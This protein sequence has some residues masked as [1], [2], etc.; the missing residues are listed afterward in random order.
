MLLEGKNVNLRIMEREDLATL[1]EW[2]NN[3]EFMGEYWELKQESKTELEKTYDNL[4]DEQWF[5]VQKKDEIKIGYISHFLSDGQ[6]ELGYFI[7][8]KERK[9][10]YVSEAIQIMIDY[11]FLSRD[12][13]RI[14]A[15]AN[16]EN[17]ASCKALERAGF[18]K[19]GILRKA[20][21]CRVEWRDDLIY[22]ILRE[23]W[24]EPKILT[25]KA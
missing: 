13:V 22:S 24:K 6:T 15:Q 18:Q 9:K 21:Y 19:G 4:K 3:P 1:H 25:K 16:P 12:I 14:Q 23:E 8:P 2:N 11:L 17:V 7:V 10:G 5:F 20:L